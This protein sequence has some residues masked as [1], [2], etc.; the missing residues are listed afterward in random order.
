MT[1]GIDLIGECNRRLPQAMRNFGVGHRRKLLN[2]YHCDV[3]VLPV[4]HRCV[5]IGPELLAPMNVWVDVIDLG[6][7]KNKIVSLHV[8]SIRLQGLLL[9]PSLTVCEA[10]FQVVDPI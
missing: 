4:A 5:A 3:L 10:K 9:L 8:H 1:F 2:I 6:V 7:T